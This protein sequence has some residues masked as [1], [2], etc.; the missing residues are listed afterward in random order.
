MKT[1]V[2]DIIAFGLLGLVIESIFTGINSLLNK[3]RLLTSTTY[4]WMI[5]IYGVTGVLISTMNDS[6]IETNI[7]IRSVYVVG[8]I[9]LVEMLS[10]LVLKLTI[11]TCPWYYSD[12]DDP[13]K[14]HKYSIIGL[15]RIDYA[16]YWYLLAIGFNLYGPKITS[17]LNY[18]SR[19]D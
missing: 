10:G 2:R 19:L 1:V 13:K 3:D 15:I 18:F 11:G 12:R 6:L 14:P 4:L 5:P 16:L 7:F 17:T 9:Y 8:L